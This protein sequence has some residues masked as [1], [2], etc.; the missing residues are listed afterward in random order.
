MSTVALQCYQCDAEYD[1]VG[2]APHP[3]RCPVC[4]SSCVPPAGSLSVVDSVHWESANGLAKVWVKAVDDRDRPVEFEVA[5]HR[6]RG[7]LVALKIDGV[8]INPQRV[9]T[10]ET[11]P[12]AITAEIAELGVSEIETPPLR[13]SK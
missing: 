11:L 1:Y 12:P 5:A 2:T 6:S 8:A 4:G 3:A 9:D 7:K 10:I 13:R